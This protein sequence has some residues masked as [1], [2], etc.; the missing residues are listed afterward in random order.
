MAPN[1]G[2]DLGEVIFKDEAVGQLD[3][4]SRFI[5]VEICTDEDGEGHETP[6]NHIVDPRPRHPFVG[7]PWLLIFSDKSVALESS[8]LAFSHITPTNMVIWVLDL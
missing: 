5:P 1:C 8:V 3:D 4:G 2:I 7:E 6:H